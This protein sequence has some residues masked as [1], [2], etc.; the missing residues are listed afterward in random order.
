MLSIG[1]E[2]PNKTRRSWT[3]MA[4][5]KSTTTSTK[6]VKAPKLDL[7]KVM[8]DLHYEPNLETAVRAYVELYWEDLAHDAAVGGAVQFRDDPA[9]Y[10]TDS[11]QN[12]IYDG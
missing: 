9:G 3:E 6:M 8:D 7:Q 4:K 12:A 2:S 10:A 5:V 11:I 1:R